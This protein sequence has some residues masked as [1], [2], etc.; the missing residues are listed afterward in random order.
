[1]SAGASAEPLQGIELTRLHR[2]ARTWAHSASGR[3]PAAVS[4]LSAE[5]GSAGKAGPAQAPDA[6]DQAEENAEP[7]PGL[8]KGETRYSFADLNALRHRMLLWAVPATLALAGLGAVLGYISVPAFSRSTQSVLDRLEFGGMT[9]A[10]IFAITGI[11]IC[12]AAAWPAETY[13][14]KQASKPLPLWLALLRLAGFW[15]AMFPFSFISLLLVGVGIDAAVNGSWGQ[16]AIRL[17]IGI[18]FGAG[19]SVLLAGSGVAVGA[20]LKPGGK[21]PASIRS[22]RWWRHVLWML[23][24]WALLLTCLALVDGV[25]GK[26]GDF[27]ETL[28]AALGSWVALAI[29]VAG[30]MPEDAFSA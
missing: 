5:A 1:V 24:L 23:A 27:F 16:A 7:E 17:A 15:L 22:S 6:H 25:Q 13:G 21:V 10:G 19:A 8:Q 2:E 3:Y 28:V 18:A 20:H 9:I 29:A 14:P 30:D 26:W 4:E 12:G 11:L